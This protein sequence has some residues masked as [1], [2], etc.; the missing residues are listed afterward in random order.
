MSTIL[1]HLSIKVKAMYD[2]IGNVYNEE[3]DYFYE[4]V[5][6]TPTKLI[7]CTIAT[8]DILKKFTSH[9]YGSVQVIEI[10]IGEDILEYEVS[11]ET[12]K[13]ESD[14]MS[15]DSAILELEFLIK[16]IVNK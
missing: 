6:I 5:V 8:S 16:E 15:S 12:G 4:G 3:S 14:S 13:I 11:Y 9:G 7:V 2:S 10:C 1:P